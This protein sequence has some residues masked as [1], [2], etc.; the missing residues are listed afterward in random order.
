L[1]YADAANIFCLPTA[2]LRKES[3]GKTGGTSHCFLNKRRNVDG[4]GAQ[5]AVAQEW[6]WGK[7]R[8]VRA[9]KLRLLLCQCGISRSSED[10]RA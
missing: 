1:G 9:E 7:R 3:Q 6:K 8:A 5:K 2:I 4:A 10:S